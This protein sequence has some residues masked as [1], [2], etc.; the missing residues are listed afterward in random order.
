MKMSNSELESVLKS[1]K[2]IFGGKYGL[3]NKEYTSKKIEYQIYSDDNNSYCIGNTIPVYYSSVSSN[4]KRQYSGSGCSLDYR[5]S[6]VKAYGEFIERYSATNLDNINDKNVIFDSFNNLSKNYNCLSLKKLIHFDEKIYDNLE[7]LYKKYSDDNLVT[8]VKG[9]DIVKNENILLPAQKV[10]LGMSLRKEEFP[11]IQWLS[12]GLACGSSKE[13]AILG[14]VYEVIERDSFVLTWKLKLP[15]KKIIMDKIKNKDLIKLYN[16]IVK[17]LTGEDNLYIYDISRTEGVYTVLTFIKNCNKSSFGLVTAAASSIDI[18]KALLKSLEELCLTYK[19]C[20]RLL[21][22]N[23]D[24]K[25]LKK[26]EVDDLDKHLLYY[27]TGDRSNRFDFIFSSNEEI[28]LS[29]MNN[30]NN[31]LFE[32]DLEYIISLFKEN[33]KSIYIADTT[34][35]EIKEIGLSVFRVIIPDYN[36]LEVNHMYKLNNNP[37]LLDYK[38]IYNREINDEPHPFP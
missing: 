27:S 19:F 16:H 3:A 17:N 24:Y 8:W 28:K 7:T 2:K 33:E 22:E 37:R 9:K 15:G 25:K 30:F 11:Y 10:F 18:E 35:S 29:E 26:E 21:F 36:D 6:L 4:D 1:M 32:S 14:A 31:S 20:Y 23:M 13:S 38:N 12:T 34:K 5:R